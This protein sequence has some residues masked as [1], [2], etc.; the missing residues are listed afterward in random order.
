[1]SLNQGGPH[2]DDVQIFTDYLRELLK[3]RQFAVDA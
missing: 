2:L 3:T 1:M